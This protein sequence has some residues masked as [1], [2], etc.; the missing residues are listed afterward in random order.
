MKTCSNCNFKNLNEARFCEK[1]GFELKP[2]I[3]LWIKIAIAVALFLLLAGC[4]I[5]ILNRMHKIAL[6]KEKIALE[7][8][9]MLKKEFFKDSFGSDIVYIDASNK[10][11]YHYFKDCTSSNH[12]EEKSVEEAF[13]EGIPDLCSTC[14]NRVSEFEKYRSEAIESQEIARKYYAIARD[15]F[16]E[17]RRSDGMQWRSDGEQFYDN[18]LKMCSKALEMRPDNTRMLNLQKRIKDEK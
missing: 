14:N 17:Q 13:S 9:V 18:A 2:P 12:A 3:P 7:K 1:C 15:H 5:F 8:E 11:C 6:E 4:A 10:Q 16:R